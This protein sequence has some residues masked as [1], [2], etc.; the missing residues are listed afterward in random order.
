VNSIALRTYPAEPAAD[1]SGSDE[2]WVKKEALLSA[3][4]AYAKAQ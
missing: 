3:L 4:V 1:L 2:K